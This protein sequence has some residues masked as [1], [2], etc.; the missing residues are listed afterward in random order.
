MSYPCL[1]RLRMALPVAIKRYPKRSLQLSEHFNVLEFACPCDRP[2]CDVVLID[3]DLPPKLEAMR[4]DLNCPVQITSGHRC[5]GHQ[6]DLDD[7][8][9]ET[10]KNSSHPRGMAV[11][12]FTG[13]H[14][15]E[16]LERAARKA[17][18]MAV[19]VGRTFIHADTRRDKERAWAYRTRK[20]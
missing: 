5:D 3:E 7:E 20:A 1:N 9:F 15:G 11:D 2:E 19:G 16:E 8:G 12:L 4:A 18:F 14:S 17:G 6:Q 13:H 10:A